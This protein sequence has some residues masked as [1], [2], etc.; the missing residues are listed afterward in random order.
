MEQI[1]AKGKEF[2]ATTGRPRRCGWFDAVL[3][4]H[5]ILINGITEVAVTKLDVLD[6]SPRV[7]I[8]TSYS[9]KGKILEF[10]PSSIDRWT[11]VEPV[12]EEHP[13]WLTDTSRAGSFEELPAQARRY[14]KRIEELLMVKIS[15]VSVGSKREQ[16]FHV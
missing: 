12:Y 10:P 6:D 2:G 15:I 5:A 14:L 16:A 1:R 13:G 4:R 7:K 3:V 11:E 9:L 8:A